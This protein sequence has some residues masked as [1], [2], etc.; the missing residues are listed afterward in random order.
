MKIKPLTLSLTLA[1]YG[2]FSQAHATPDYQSEEAKT[3][4]EK[5]VKAHGGYDRWINASSFQFTAMM[6]LAV[7]DIG[8]ER[9]AFDNW[10]YYTVT[11]EP[12]TSRAYVDVLFEPNKGPEVAYDGEQI[13]V[14]PYSFDEPQFRDG[15]VQLMWFHYAIVALP[16]MTQVDGV[17]HEYI[18][19]KK[20][21]NDDTEYEVVRMSFDPENKVHSG[22]MDLYIDPE[23]SR[24]KAWTQ[25]AMIPILPGNVLPKEFTAGGGGTLRIID[26]Y[27]ET[28]G[29]V[30][31]R[32][33]ASFAEENNDVT[34]A[35]LILNPSLNLPFD[36]NALVAP[37]EA[38]SYP[39]GPSNQ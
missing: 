22:L 34:G 6:Y 19:H 29:L 7:L 16:F 1:L 13:W 3:T 28:N 18:G 37:V 38:K 8:D 17:K 20:L 33:Y 5:M 30:I 12:K 39:F 11:V 4:I 23:T 24:L 26:E 35:H 9:T 15:P 21:P 31:A 36:E 14:V 10:R 25:G 2:I 32:S 27:L